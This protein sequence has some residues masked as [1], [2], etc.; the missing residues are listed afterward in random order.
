MPSGYTKIIEEQGEV[1]LAQFAM[2]CARGMMPLFSLHDADLDEPIPPKLTA[3]PHYTEKVVECEQKLAQ[4]SAM[5]VQDAAALLETRHAERVVEVERWNTTRSILQ[6]NCERLRANVDAWV[7]PTPDHA[8]LKKFMLDQLDTEIR[9]ATIRVDLPVK[10]SPEQWLAAL[11]EDAHK[12]LDRA[13]RDLTEELQRTDWNNKWLADLRES[14]GVTTP[15]R[16]A[17]K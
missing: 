14:L 5:T 2:R 3:N 16:T 4:I 15:Y 7:P 17:T 1:T 13:K 9:Y 6:A 11:A 10:Q 8:A 12:E